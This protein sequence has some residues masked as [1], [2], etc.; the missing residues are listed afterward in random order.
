M[1]FAR[2]QRRVILNETHSWIGQSVQ[3]LVRTDIP[4]QAGI[5]HWTVPASEAPVRIECLLFWTERLTLGGIFNYYPDGGPW[6]EKPH[7]TLTLVN[8]TLRRQGIGTALLREAM[9]RWPAI[10]L[11]TQSYSDDGWAFVS[12]LILEDR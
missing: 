12:S 1:T 4:R 6:G 10:D 5:V 8:P 2:P 3:Y 9:S 7:D 11:S